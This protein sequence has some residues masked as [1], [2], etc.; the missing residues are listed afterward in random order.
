MKDD[1][2][3][4]KIMI[5][6]AQLVVSVILLKKIE[7]KILIVRKREEECLSVTYTVKRITRIIVGLHFYQDYSC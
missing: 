6:L 4:A 5:S 1:E 7:L 2:K 3:K